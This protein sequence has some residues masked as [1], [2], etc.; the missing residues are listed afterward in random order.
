MKYKYLVIN[1]YKAL[2][3]LFCD[4]FQNDAEVLSGKNGQEALDLMN[5][6]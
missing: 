5:A 2:R 4:I 3:E 6:H 1:N